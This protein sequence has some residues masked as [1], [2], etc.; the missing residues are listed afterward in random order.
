MVSS[1]NNLILVRGANDSVSAVAHRLFKSGY[2][3]AMH[4]E[5]TPTTAR[6]KMSFTDI[7]FDAYTLLEGIEARLFVKLDM[8]E[9]ALLTHEYISLNV[10]YYEIFLYTLRPA[11]LVDARMRKNKQSEVQRALADLTIGLG[12]NLIAGVITDLA[13]ETS[14]GEFLRQVIEH[15][16]TRHLAGEPREIQGHARDRYLYAPSAGIFRSSFQIGDQVSPGQEV[17]RINNLPLHAPNA[18]VLRGLTH[19]G[20]PVTLKTKVVEID[21]RGEKAQISGIG[22]RQAKIAEGVLSAIRAWKGKH[23]H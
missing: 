5:L 15:E 16:A 6:R 19:N 7:V 3:V 13:V 21:P 1:Y 11:V 18:G 8:L 20:V 22:E 2:A 23:V 10:G 4:E 12:P 14:W 17:T 9:N